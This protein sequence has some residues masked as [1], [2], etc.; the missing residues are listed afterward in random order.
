MYNIYIQFHEFNSNSEPTL[1]SYFNFIICSVSHFISAVFLRQDARS[2]EFAVKVVF[3]CQIYSDEL[4]FFS[5][6]VIKNRILCFLT[7]K[8]AVGVVL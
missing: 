1:Y 5:F 6:R 2:V 4:T 7:K 8:S 3:H